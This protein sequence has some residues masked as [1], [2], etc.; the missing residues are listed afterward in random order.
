MS[1][2]TFSHVAAHVL[3]N[4]QNLESILLSC[5]FQQSGVHSELLSLAASSSSLREQVLERFT[6]YMFRKAK[7][8][9]TISGGSFFFSKMF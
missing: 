1:E 8:M 6:I 5:L 9:A 4:Q 3:V 2:G 7:G